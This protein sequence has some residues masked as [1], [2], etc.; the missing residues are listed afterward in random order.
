[1]ESRQTTKISACS[2]KNFFEKLDMYLKRQV[3]P[4][5][6]VRAINLSGMETGNVGTP[7]LFYDIMWQVVFY[8]LSH[9]LERRP[10]FDDLIYDVVR[11]ERS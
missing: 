4:Q 2:K 6:I 1:M 5:L 10:C 3:S 11:E 7:L 8:Y 9:V